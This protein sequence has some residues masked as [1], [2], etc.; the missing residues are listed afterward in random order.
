MASALVYKDKQPMKEWPG[1]VHRMAGKNQAMISPEDEKKV[2]CLHPADVSGRLRRG[3]V[4]PA[5]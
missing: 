1:I 3:V 5:L 2:M 4:S